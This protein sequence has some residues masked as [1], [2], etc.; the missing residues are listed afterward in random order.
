MS[1]GLPDPF[2]GPDPGAGARPGSR[3]DRHGRGMRGPLAVGG[4][5]APDGVPVARTRSQRFDDLV[6]DAVEE[7]ERR[8]AK[9]LS[10]V[11]FAVEDVPDPTTGPD[12]E[13]VPLGVLV[14]PGPNRPARIVIYRRPIELRTVGSSE[15][16][17][18][19]H[20]VVVEQVAELLGVDPEQ[21]DPEYGTEID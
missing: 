11:E 8:Y 18:L 1:G 2:A 13:D 4:P 10:G 20:D 9:E 14:E 3:R 6:L 12:E 7:L 21:I 15:L 19:V 16:S 17:A 5:L